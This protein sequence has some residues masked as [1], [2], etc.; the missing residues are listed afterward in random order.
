MY[1][2]Y[3]I[4][5]KLLKTEDEF[6]YKVQFFF[7]KELALPLN[8]CQQRNGFGLEFFPPP[9]LRIFLFGWLVAPYWFASG[10]LN[11]N[12]CFLVLG[13]LG[14]IPFCLLLTDTFSAL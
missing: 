8:L 3:I 5:D 11:K 14:G 12:I 1:R 2:L 4:Y 10:H 13:L 7:S 9:D 6:Y